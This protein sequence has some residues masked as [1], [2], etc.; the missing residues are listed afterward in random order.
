MTVFDAD[1]VRAQVGS[2]RYLGGRFDRQGTALVDPAR[3]AWGLRAACLQAGVRMYERTPVLALSTDAAGVRLR[4]PYGGIRAARVALAGNAFPPLLNRIRRFVVPMYGYVVVTEPLNPV[5]RKEVGWAGRQGVVD[6]GNRSHYY[7]L[8][9]DDRIL[10]GG[11]DVI[12]Y[13]GNEFGSQ[14]EQR[15]AA[16]ALLVTHL[17]ETFPQLEGIRISHA[18]GAAIDVCSR[19]SPFWGVAHAGRVAYVAGF[20]GIGVAATRFGA[21]VMLDLLERRDTELTGMAMVR[22][23]PL[24]FPPEPLRGIGV[25]LT[26]WS[27]DRADS[28]DGHRNLWLRAINR[29]GAGFGS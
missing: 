24:P 7:R 20:S 16:F 11:N 25:D 14:H 21:A 4:V 19:F 10:F 17:M 28:N 23:R 18:W 29:L 22:G 27:L 3:L 5:R 12:H 6:A 8:T 1:A 13:R 15:P 2:P 9:A 26:R